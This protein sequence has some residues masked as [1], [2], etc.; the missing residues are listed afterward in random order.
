M[1]AAMLG[2]CGPRVPRLKSLFSSLRFSD[3]VSSLQRDRQAELQLVWQEIGDDK[4]QKLEELQHSVSVAVHN[5]YERAMEENMR[6]K[7]DLEDM[8]AKSEI[9]LKELCGP[10]AL[11]VMASRDLSLQA[12]LNINMT[13][14]KAV[15]GSR[16]DEYGWVGGLVVLVKLRQR[17]AA[18]REML[19]LPPC[20]SADLDEVLASTTE[21]LH[22][23]CPKKIA[24]VPSITL[25]KSGQKPIFQRMYHFYHTLCAIENDWMHSLVTKDV[26]KVHDIL[27]FSERPVRQ[28]LQNELREMIARKSVPSDTTSGHSVK[29]SSSK[30]RPKSRESRHAKLCS[31][32]ASALEH[33]SNQILRKLDKINKQAKSLAQ[34]TGGNSTPFSQCSWSMNSPSLR[35]SETF[36]DSRH[37]SVSVSPSSDNDATTPTSVLPESRAFTPNPGYYSED[38]PETLDACWE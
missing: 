9:Q 36:A 32:E 25:S 14:L 10:N 22:N 12:R 34:P 20:D 7:A 27:Q 19:K 5:I 28:C 8:V 16:I 4:Y 6:R 15:E 3:D 1:C 26:D 38:Q 35:H 33:L 13:Q 29:R 37:R 17:I 18:L 24:L 30:I 31:D 23:L 11:Q 21:D 2:Q